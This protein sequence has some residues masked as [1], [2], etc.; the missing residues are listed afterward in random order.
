MKEQQDVLR[1]IDCLAKLLPGIAALIAGIFIP[2]VINHNADTNRNHQL[3]M[4]IISKR[5]VADSELRARMFENLITSFFGENTKD[6]T[7]DEK[8]LKLRL[9]ALNFHESFDF[10]PLFESL[11]SKFLEEKNEGKLR[12]L[13]DIAKEVLGKQEA[14]LA[15]IK[16]GK[17]FS[18]KVKQGLENAII[19]PND[20]P[21]DSQA[22]YKGN[23]LGITVSKIA[24]N[25]S[26]VHI[27]LQVI[28]DRETE[29]GVKND[30]EFNVSY[31]DLPYIDNT[32]I[33]NGSR[34]A[35]TLKSVVT[36]SSDGSKAADLSI[37]F[38]PESYMSS[39]D[40]PFLDEML[41]Y[42]NTALKNG[43]K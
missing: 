9:I 4:D 16:E 11:E 42:F 40:R 24:E 10:K 6:K 34:F 27:Q 32:K 36:D 1:W 5:E 41:N 29:F 3:Y 14:L 19:I 20:S 39:R 21:P 33:Y 15:Q 35:I 13:R 8:L 31:F 43:R 26:S 28:A 30:L 22:S 25:E 38:F 18:E 37:M 12:Q 17:V 7:D 2:L 23:R